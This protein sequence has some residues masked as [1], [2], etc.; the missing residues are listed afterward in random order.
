MSDAPP[1]GGELRRNPVNGKLVIVA[2]ARTRR[3]SDLATPSTS[4]PGP[5][6]FCAGREALTPPEVDAVRPGGGPPDSPGWRV[7]V[8]P[9]KYPALA[10]RHE[11]IVHSPDHTA[12]L[13]DL[14]DSALLEVLEMWRRRLAAQYRAGAAAAILFVNR[15][16]EAGASLAH[17]HEQLVA[18]PV[19][20]PLLLDELLAF[21]RYRERY[22]GCVLCS[23]MEGAGARAVFGGEMTAWVPAAPR[24]AGELW[25]APAEH[26]AD[27]IAADPRPLAGGLRRALAAVSAATGRAP[28]NAWLHTAPADLRG[29]FHWHLEIAPR[30]STLAGL[31]LG[32]DISLVGLD[33][34]AAA[35]AYRE[36]LP[37]H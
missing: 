1:S 7:R 18:T 26:E 9:N 24:F 3:P 19:V 36:A 33:P 22:G 34:E 15:G 5:C 27:L 21:E 12:E 2:P 35:E 28:L 25:L 6:P 31:E 17:P 13:E 29:A 8:V 20:P 32:A 23:E 30:L 10:G 4:P 14:D 16:R 37:P 11:V